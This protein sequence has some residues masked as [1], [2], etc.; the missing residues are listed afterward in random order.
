MMGRYHTPLSIAICSLAS[1]CA[2]LHHVQVGELNN[3]PKYALR[4]FELKV[5]ETGVDFEEAGKVAKALNGSKTGRSDIDKVNGYIQMFQQ[6]PRTGNPVFSDSYA[7]N[8]VNDLYKECPSG[9]ITGVTSIRE[10]RKYPVISGEIVK[11]KGY[12]MMPKSAK[13]ADNSENESTSPQEESL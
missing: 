3:D 4:P 13:K 6:G 11:V 9:K 12:C 10:T 1:S 5:S 7:K 8:I 2:A